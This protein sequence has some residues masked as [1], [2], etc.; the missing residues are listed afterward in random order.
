MSTREKQKWTNS[1]LHKLFRMEI[2]SRHTLIQAEERGEIPTADRE[3]RG[4][5]NT[6]VWKLEQLPMIG[7]K[8]GFLKK[9]PKQIV[10]CV[11]TPKGGVLKTATSGNIARIAALN[12][13]KTLVIGLDFQKSI[14]NFL[15]PTPEFDT[16]EQLQNFIKKQ[17]SIGLFH[18]LYQGAP[19]DEIIKKTSIPT[20]DIIPET[21]DLIALEK[22]LRSETRRE[23]KFY[24]FIDQNLSQYELIILDNTPSWSLLTECSLTAANNLISPLGCDFE[25]LQALGENFIH[26][27]DFSRKMRIKW[28]NFLIIPTLLEKNNVSQDVYNVY[29]RDFQDMILPAPIRR[30]VKGQEARI[31][32]MSAIEYDSKSDLANDYFEMISALWNRIIRIKDKR[33]K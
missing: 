27:E 7:E 17:R 6:R 2:K 20:L 33:H 16:L 21:P 12:G 26:I 32:N 5:T 29:I 23:Y 22:T 10:L 4:S 19:L 13:I 28:D 31:V 1:E 18:T 9:P 25:T 30:T 15:L 24:D 11:Y 14:T 3:A 8:Y